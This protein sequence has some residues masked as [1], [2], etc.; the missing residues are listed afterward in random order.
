M[1]NQDSTA[2]EGSLLTGRNPTGTKEED[3]GQFD[4]FKCCLENNTVIET[5][6]VIY[7]TDYVY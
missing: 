5:T 1:S 2:A 3:T 6:I 7:N 4:S